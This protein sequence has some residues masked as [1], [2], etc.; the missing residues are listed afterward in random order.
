MLIR[1]ATF[2]D[3]ESL[4]PLAREALLNS[5]FAGLE[6]D[7]SV[8]QRSYVTAM[9]FDDGFAKVVTSKGEVVGGM[10]GIVTNNHLGLRCAIDL[11]TYSR[12]GTDRLIKLFKQWAKKKEVQF[13]QITDL[14]GKKR[15]QKLITSL[16]FESAGTNFIGVI[17]NG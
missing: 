16:G 1:D 6:V 17:Q 2:R 3:L 13:I 7:E 5:V 14:S 4:L 11:F 9:Q 12:M 15:Y 8:I 10:I